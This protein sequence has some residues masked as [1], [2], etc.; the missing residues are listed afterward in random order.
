MHISG[1]SFI[2]FSQRRLILALKFSFMLVWFGLPSSCQHFFFLPFSSAGDVGV[3]LS[4]PES[5][6][7][8]AVELTGWQGPHSAGV[9]PIICL[10]QDTRPGGAPVAA[11]KGG[12]ASCGAAGKVEVGGACCR[13]S[14][15]FTA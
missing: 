9:Q 12:V 2:P 10:R 1:T 13:L 5:V 11:G 8:F 15:T 7:R 6:S 14:L 4:D 3:T